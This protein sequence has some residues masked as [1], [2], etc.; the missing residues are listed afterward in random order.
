MIAEKLEKDPIEIA[1]I[2]VHGPTSQEDPDPL[3]SLEACIE[4]A[5]KMMNWKWHGTGEKKLTGRQDA[6]CKLQI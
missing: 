4:A 3:P 6:W 5:K 1:R 2:N